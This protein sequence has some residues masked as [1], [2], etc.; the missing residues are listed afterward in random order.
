MTDPVE[1][2]RDFLESDAETREVV[3]ALRP[4]LRK[5]LEDHV[6]ALI[7]NDRPVSDP[8]VQGHLDRY[9]RDR[10]VDVTCKHCGRPWAIEAA[11][12]KGVLVPEDELHRLQATVVARGN[13]LEDAELKIGRL[14]HL[15]AW[16][17]GWIEDQQAIPGLQ[18]D[19][20][21]GVADATEWVSL[22]RNAHWRGDHK[23]LCTD[24]RFRG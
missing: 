5:R 15:L 8:Y 23:P 21:E 24:K 7:Q 10:E 20:R 3:L 6:L 2:L 19:E 17:A 16:A 22:H 18:V 11:F 14:R 12:R 13:L 9:R 4:D 1:G